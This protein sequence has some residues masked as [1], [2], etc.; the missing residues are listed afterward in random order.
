VLQHS[1]EH[2]LTIRLTDELL[3]WLKELSRRTGLPIGRIICQQLEMAKTA[4]RNQQFLSLAGKI[5][6]RKNLASQGAFQGKAH[7]NEQQYTVNTVDESDVGPLTV[8]PR[9][10]LGPAFTTEATKPNR[11]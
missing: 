5:N 8:A 10:L 6:G 2:R 7:R 1:Y 4:K 11:G 9:V 3:A